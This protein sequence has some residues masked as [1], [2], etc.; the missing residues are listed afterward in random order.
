MQKRGCFAGLCVLALLLSGCQAGA[1][2]PAAASRAAQATTPVAWYTHTAIPLSSATASSTATATATGTAT[3]TRRPTLTPLPTFAAYNQIPETVAD[4]WQ[5]GSLKAAG[6]DGVKLSEMLEAIYHG[7]ER[8]DTLRRID[9]GEKLQNIHGILIARHGRLVFEEYFYHYRR[10]NWH[11]LASVTKSVTS[12][13]VG[14][15]IEQGHLEGVEQA[16]LPFFE[17]YQPLPV[18]DERRQRLTV[19]DLLTMRPGM[20]CD[21]WS[22]TSPTYYDSSYYDD[23]PDLVEWSLSLPML[24]EPGEEFTYCSVATVLLGVVLDQATGMSVQQ[25][26]KQF[27]LAPLGISSYIWSMVP[28]GWVDTAGS[29]QMSMRD[30]LK[31]GQMALDGGMWDGQQI[32]P[33]TWIEQSV[34][35]HVRL[36]FNQSWGNYYGYLW[37]LGDSRLGRGRST[38]HSFSASGAGGQ[39]ITVFPELEMVVVI[40]GWNIDPDIGAPFLIMDSWILPAVER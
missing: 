16:V 10:T 28:G 26:S 19:E 21:D 8:G 29:M 32:V 14:I 17:Q 23:H 39:V 35:K 9:G 27:L 40:T 25:F 7:E 13:L 33:Q 3:P 6:I 12:L 34:K 22:R 5:T 2:L 37:W 15:A 18:P 30:M 11:N 4:G 31:L 1:G 20:D 36:E 24:R 38:V